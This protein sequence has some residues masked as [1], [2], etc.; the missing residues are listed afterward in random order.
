MPALAQVVGST[1]LYG[2]HTNLGSAHYWQH[3]QVANTTSVSQS[4]NL[5][6]DTDNAQTQRA[7]AKELYSF[8]HK[9]NI[10]ISA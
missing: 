7:T 10:I 6:F 9:T 8:G 5:G 1:C 4:F 3:M 2:V